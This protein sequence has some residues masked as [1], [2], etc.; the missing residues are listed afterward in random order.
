VSTPSPTAIRPLRESD[1]ELCERWRDNFERL[2]RE[3]KLTLESLAE[4]SGVDVK[5]L[6]R[7]SLGLQWPSLDIVPAIAR[8]LGTT[9]TAL[10]AEPRSP[11]VIMRKETA[12]WVRSRDSLIASRPLRPQERTTAVQTYELTLQPGAIVRSEAHPPGTLTNLV[13][14]AGALDIEWDS[15]LQQLELGDAIHFLSDSPHAFLNRASVAARLY[16]VAQFLPHSHQH[17]YPLY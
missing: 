13:V 8:A 10:L 5:T 3:R 4:R 9:S 1:E 6:R 11:T 12:R 16:L 7:F 2:R 17:A 14:V 15:Q